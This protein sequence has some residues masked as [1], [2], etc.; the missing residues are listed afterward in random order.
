MPYYSEVSPLESAFTTS[1]DNFT[2]KYF[3]NKNG[4]SE[5]RGW[6]DYFEVV[7]RRNLVQGGGQMSFRD[8][9]SIDNGNIAQFNIT[10]PQTASVWNVTDGI[11]IKQLNTSFSGG[12]TSFKISTPVLNEF[13]SF[14]DAVNNFFVPVNMGIVPNQNLHASPFADLIIVAHPNFLAQAN[15]LADHRKQHDGLRVLVTT[16]QLIYNE[17]SSGAQDITAIR[18]F[19]RMLY[20]KATTPADEP[21]YLL[22]FGDAS[23]NYKETKVFIEADNRFY[24]NTNFVPTFESDNYY[25]TDSYASDDYFGLLDDDEG[26][27]LPNGF[28][29]MDIGIGRLPVGT[30]IQAE[31][32]I[33]KIL[34][35][36]SPEALGD[37]RNAL[38]YVADDQE[39]NSHLNE[40]QQVSNIVSAAHS[41]F[42]I[43]KIYLD[44]YK[45]ISLGS[46]YSYPDATDALN[47]GI[48]RGTLV[49]N[50]TG[51]GSS[52]QLAHE[53]LVT[54][55]R[56][57]LSWKNKN[58]MPIFV[59]ATCEFTEFDHIAKVSAGEDVILNPNG[60]GIALLTTTRVAYSN[61]NLDLNTNFNK[62]NAFEKTKDGGARLGDIMKKTK[63]TNGRN[64][65]PSA[66]HF[67]LLGD[68][69]M[70]IAVPKYNVVT[71]KINNKNVTLDN[72][73]FKALQNV[74]IEGFVGDMQNNPLTNFN[75]EVSITVYDKAGTYST[76][77]NDQDSYKQT[78]TM[79]KNFIFKGIAAVVNGSFKIDLVIPKDIVYNFGLGKISYYASD[80]TNNVDG[81]GSYNKIVI[82][83]SDNNAVADDEGPTIKL[84][85]NDTTFRNGGS[86]HQN[87]LLL[88]HLF[89]K[90]GINTSGVSV[91]HE[92][93]AILD[94]D[95]ANPSVLNDFYEGT[96]NNFQ[97]GTIHFPY[98]NLSLGNHTIT[99]K[100]W[101]IYNNSGTASIDF[102][103]I[104]KNELKID[105][106]MNYP[107]PFIKTTIFS[108]EHNKAGESMDVTIDIFNQLGELVMRLNVPHSNGS[109]RFDELE[110]NGQNEFGALLPAG[111]YTFKATVKDKEGNTTQQSSRLIILR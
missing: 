35:Y 34:R 102:L 9:K 48:Q 23:F 29:A 81:A 65:S 95:I 16:P 68:P 73:T 43:N 62:E 80:K 51:H 20:N 94:N 104:D 69:S 89:D 83:G 40:S 91:G 87:P 78:F 77:A 103:V 42:N 37:W 85:I 105:K 92:M 25:D 26:L 33:D 57:I 2:I 110:W 12:I 108:F 111:M 50:Y 60:G 4:N 41:E 18:E 75:G 86:T 100:V 98:Y 70:R 72:D 99:V 36:E 21:K 64:N 3:F 107:N 63:N 54:V 106:L 24:D 79:Q 31:Q 84:F 71:T 17:F 97:K 67:I 56:D 10:T 52:L 74:S 8:S 109:A 53:S 19:I 1:S 61:V 14:T 66:K 15:R 82:G 28:E 5:A 58:A 47:R 6:L 44:A 76:L 101:D 96:L 13:I 32:M 90:N 88:A 55:N 59:T 93:T 46:G 22:L 39:Y 30:A 7:A 11:N 27:W 38:M 49:V 45:Q